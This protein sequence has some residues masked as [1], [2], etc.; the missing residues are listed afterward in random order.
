MVNNGE[1]FAE[2][3]KVLKENRDVKN[4][5]DRYLHSIRNTIEDKEKLENKINSGDKETVQDA[6][7]EH[8]EWL[9]NNQDADKEDYEE[10]LKD[11]QGIW[12]PI[13]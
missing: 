3:D 11:L 7:K 4:S 13:I 6:L 1:K 5:F 8:Q 9:D 10:H 2:E 12:N